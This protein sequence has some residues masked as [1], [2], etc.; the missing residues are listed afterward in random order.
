MQ[1]LMKYSRGVR[2][3]VAGA[4]LA[5][6]SGAM[7]NGKQTLCVWDILGAQAMSST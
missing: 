7:A 3:L 1:T 2:A 4:A 5:V 6:S